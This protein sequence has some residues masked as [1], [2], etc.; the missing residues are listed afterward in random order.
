MTEVDRLGNIEHWRWVPDARW[1]MGYWES[2]DGGESVGP[3]PTTEDGKPEF[4]PADHLRGAVDRIAELEADLKR[5]RVARRVVDEALR[6]A[7]ARPDA[8]GP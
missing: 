1:P 7:L 8:G 2:D 6:D 3:I 4:V 5:E